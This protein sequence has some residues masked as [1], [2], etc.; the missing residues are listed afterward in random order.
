M[1]QI[2]DIEV[3]L[4]SNIYRYSDFQLD[5][6]FYENHRQRPLMAEERKIERFCADDVWHQ[7]M[8]F[9]LSIG[10]VKY[11]VDCVA[12]HCHLDPSIV[13]SMMDRMKCDGNVELFHQGG[14]WHYNLLGRD[15]ILDKFCKAELGK[16]NRGSKIQLAIPGYSARTLIQRMACEFG[17]ENISFAVTGVPVYDFLSEYKSIPKTLAMHV[18]PHQK[19]QKVFRDI[20]KIKRLRR[21]IPQSYFDVTF[22]IDACEDYAYENFK[23][24]SGITFANNLQIY[25]DI[26]KGSLGVDIDPNAFRWENLS[27]GQK[28]NG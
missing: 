2:H 20:G 24:I 7:L 18:R 10:S 22:L 28:N 21:T 26:L 5:C 6:H 25:L 19:L 27:I 13:L 16:P 4:G 23:T 14:V 9:I 12:K 11:P 1:K 15:S 17:N 8:Y 3:G